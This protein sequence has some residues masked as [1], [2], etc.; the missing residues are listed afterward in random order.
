MC[1]PPP[2]SPPHAVAAL[3]LNVDVFEVLLGPAEGF[4]VRI[5]PWAFGAPPPQ[6]S[7][8]VGVSAKGDPL[9]AALASLINPSTGAALLSVGFASARE[10][11]VT[12]TQGGRIL[13]G[14]W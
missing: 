9:L 5:A 3:E 8:V 6:G 13:A 4:E 1:V 12:V 11:L 10:P 14:P 2:P 7:V